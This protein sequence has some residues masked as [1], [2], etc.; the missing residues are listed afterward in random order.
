[1]ALFM[2]LATS[3][4]F[5]HYKREAL[6]MNTPTISIKNNSSPL[7]CFGFNRHPTSSIQRYD[8]PGAYTY[9]V[10]LPTLYPDDKLWV[11]L[12]MTLGLPAV[13]PKL[14][15]V[16]STLNIFVQSFEIEMP[17]DARPSLRDITFGL[18][19]DNTFIMVVP[20]QQKWLLFR[21]GIKRMKKMIS[22]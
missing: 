14:T 17:K 20:R 5:D 2:N 9:M 3:V 21:R 10:K 18:T 22:K 4:E 19:E 1:M 8:A 11:E 13:R 6:R 7:A 15:V 12:E 16:C